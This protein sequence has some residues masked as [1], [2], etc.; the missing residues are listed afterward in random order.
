MAE[1]AVVATIPDTPAAP[2]GE[3]APAA[4]WA[5]ADIAEDEEIEAPA[6]EAGQDD[7]GEVKPGT[8]KAPEA[9]PKPPETPAFDPAEYGL[10][11]SYAHCKTPH[12]A[13]RLV[14]SRRK[15]AEAKIAEQGTELGELRKAAK[16]P[17]KPAETPKVE[18]VK[19]W[20][21]EDRRKLHEEFDE[22]PEE[23]FAWLGQQIQGPIVQQ[24]QTVVADVKATRAEIAELR[25]DVDAP[26]KQKATE[27]VAAFFAETP[28][29]VPL[30]PAMVEMYGRLN[31][32]RD[33]N[34][35]F[36]VYEADL[37]GLAQLEASDPAAFGEVFPLVAS[38]KVRFEKAMKFI[39]GN[40]EALPK[41]AA[42]D[43][44]TKVRAG[45]AAG[46]GAGAG[47]PAL[48]TSGDIRDGDE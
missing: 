22:R 24:L 43:A 7:K 14:E 21:L 44:R 37:F 19:P 42:L 6:V 17:E 4:E 29:A 27:E 26:I 38:G 35:S 30:R 12:E 25:G 20:T 39:K 40:T 15:Q 45:A 47:P 5:G 34:H 31:E 9:K 23:V 28:E 10:D 11:E 32:G 16:P 3:T 41:A 8:A 48:I 18:E 1:D 2:A 46:K 13:M 36:P 33:A